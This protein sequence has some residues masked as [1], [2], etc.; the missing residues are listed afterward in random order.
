[1]SIALIIIA[2]V[3]L[4]FSFVVVRGAPYVPSHRRQLRFAFD[5]L[6]PLSSDD[7][8]VDLGS[9]DGVVLLEA[10]RRGAGG[11]GYE[12]NPFLVLISRWRCRKFSNI[13]FHTM[14][15]TR[16]KKLPE[17]ATVVYAFT[18]GHSIEAIGRCLRRWSEEQDLY[19]ISYGFTL[20][21]KE[22]IKQQGPMNLYHYPKQA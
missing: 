1:M 2:V 6:Y 17:A 13:H 7:Y 20:K 3:F 10:A 14:D 18:T 11:A 9:G 15:Y 21:N 22:P 16:V 5:E 19:F 12:L 4:S 8:V